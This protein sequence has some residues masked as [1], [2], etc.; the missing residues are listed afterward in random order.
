MSPLTKFRVFLSI[1]MLIC[2]VGITYK[3]NITK[4]ELK[5]NTITY[6]SYFNGIKKE[7]LITDEMYKYKAA[8]EAINIAM[9]TREEED[10]ANAKE[11][12][13]TIT[14]ETTKEE[15]IETINQLEQS[16]E[17]DKVIREIVRLTSEATTLD[18]IEKIGALLS[19]V[20]VT[21][22]RNDLERD[23]N[24]IKQELLVS[25]INTLLS[26]VNSNKNQSELDAVKELIQKITNK[27]T[28]DNL[29]KETNNIQDAINKS[30][31][32]SA[33][34][35]YS[36]TGM[37][38]QALETIKGDISGYGPN[39][40]GCSGYTAS[41]KNVMNGNIYYYDKTYGN[42]RIVASGPEYPFGTIVKM[43]SVSYYGSDIYAIVLDR[44]GVIGKGRHRLFDLLFTSESNASIF[45]VSHSTDCEILRIGY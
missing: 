38:G 7:N 19:K 45:G 44:G 13:R 8:S 3:F 22:I 25:N 16:Y 24:A 37:S 32:I 30:K 9:L 6:L 35:S 18:E 42:I 29:E 26:K 4:R 36:P 17:E 34:G 39:C 12:I 23:L 5:E 20:S 41:G 10:L 43:K 15:L 31:A 33:V 11:L 21:D 28:K 14:S 27:D 2:I 40:F 1:V